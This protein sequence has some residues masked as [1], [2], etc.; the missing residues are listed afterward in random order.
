MIKFKNLIDELKYGSDMRIHMSKKPIELKQRTFSQ[1]NSMKPSGFWYGFGNEWID[2]VRSEMPQW[3][4]NYIYEVDIG[5]SNVLQ[6]KNGEELE[7]FHNEYVESNISEYNIKWPE[8]S[9]KYDGIEINPYQWEARLEYS[10]YYGWD[11]ASGCV[12][13]LSN[14]KLKLITDKGA[15][16]D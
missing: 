1:Q 8:V 7:K 12:W 5:S 9:K 6:I 2:W 11:I 15:D 4:G 13:N 10:W 14:V 3:E 16:K